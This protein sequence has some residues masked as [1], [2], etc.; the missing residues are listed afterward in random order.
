M[1]IPG[2][3]GGTNVERRPG[4]GL[5]LALF[6]AGA[7]CVGAVVREVFT[8]KDVRASA[9][10][11]AHEVLERSTDP[12]ARRAAV[13][14]VAD[15]AIDAIECLQAVAKSTDVAGEHARE[16]LRQ[17]AALAAGGK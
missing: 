6:F 13:T 11:A 3:R 16:Y 7:C 10:H 12:G 17:I 4:R 9:A 14:R 2:V 5:T 1:A 8:P 15:E